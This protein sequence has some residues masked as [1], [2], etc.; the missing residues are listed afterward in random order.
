MSINSK[1]LRTKRSGDGGDMIVFAIIVV[2]VLAFFG[3]ITLN[4]HI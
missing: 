2:A 1:F 4:F 3:F